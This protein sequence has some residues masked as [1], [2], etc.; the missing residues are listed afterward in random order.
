MS[1]NH[2]T[3][4]RRIHSKYS[5]GSGPSESSSS[6]GQRYSLSPDTSFPAY[7]TDRNDRP[8]R[9]PIDPQPIVQLRVNDP[10]DP[11]KYVSYAT[12]TPPLLTCPVTTYKVLTFSCV[13]PYILQM[14]LHLILLHTIHSQVPQYPLFTDSKTWT[15]QV[16]SLS[17]P[18]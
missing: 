13:A 1:T 7:I 14:R 16:L 4:Q 8:D 18:C 10:E 3:S 9:K 11:A 5:P 15:I 2:A 17:R 12:E 6:E